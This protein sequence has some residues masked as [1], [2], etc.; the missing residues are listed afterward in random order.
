MGRVGCRSREEGAHLVTVVTGVAV[1]HGETTVISSI[2]V[3]KGFVIA[4]APSQGQRGSIR[5]VE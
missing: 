1:V 4:S 2:G 5:S 3:A